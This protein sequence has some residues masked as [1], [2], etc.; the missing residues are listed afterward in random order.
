MRKY[1]RYSILC[2]Y[3][4]K[5]LEVLDATR[6]EDSNKSH[7]KNYAIRNSNDFPAALLGGRVMVRAYGIT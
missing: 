3:H 2:C 7:L 6:K 1:S 5:D 4:K